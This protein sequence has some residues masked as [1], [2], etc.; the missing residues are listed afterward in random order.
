MKK[1]FGSLILATFFLFSSSSYAAFS[2]TNHLLSTIVEE[3]PEA[4]PYEV[5]EKFFEE[6]PLKASLNDFQYYNNY[7][8]IMSCVNATSKNN[9]INSEPSLLQSTYLTKGIPSNG[10]LFPGTP[11]VIQVI[12]GT[13]S[14]FPDNGYL[15]KIQKISSDERSLIIINDYSR[16]NGGT[17]YDSTEFRKS[18]YLLVS[19]TITDGIILRYTYCWQK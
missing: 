18:G 5:L 2:I 19:R 8:E 6:A 4:H 7:P 9:E 17:G 16:N 1:I 14:Y 13:A 11:D 12:I 15:A 3:N 10:P